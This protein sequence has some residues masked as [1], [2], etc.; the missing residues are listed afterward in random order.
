MNSAATHKLSRDEH[1]TQTVMCTK[2]ESQ[3]IINFD[4]GNACDKTNGHAGFV[5]Q[6]DKTDNLGKIKQQLVLSKMIL[7]LNASKR[8]C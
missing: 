3:R 2:S 5:V 4:E 7:L 6:N 1:I 8:K